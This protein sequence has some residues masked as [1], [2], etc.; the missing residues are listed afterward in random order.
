MAIDRDIRDE[1]LKE[2]EVL[3]TDYRM[4][5]WGVHLHVVPFSAAPQ[6]I[7]KPLREAE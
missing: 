3:I 7:I 2:Y 1:F 6:D 5:I 4:C